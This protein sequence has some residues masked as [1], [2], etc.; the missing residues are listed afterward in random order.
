MKDVLVVEGALADPASA[1]VR[2]DDRGLLYGE[3][4]FETVR[5]YAGLPFAVDEHLGLLAEACA[6]F[7][8]LPFPTELLL[9]SI[10]VA[11]G[12]RAGAES[13]LR[14]V[15]TGGCAP[16]GALARPARLS[17]YV[18]ATDLPPE[19]AELRRRGAKLV[20]RPPVFGPGGEDLGLA[21]KSLSYLPQIA[22][23]RHA[24]RSGADEVLIVSDTGDVREGATA[25]IV[26]V[27][28]GAL[29]TPSGFL[30]AGV[31]ARQLLA[32][33]PALGLTPLRRRTVLSDLRDADGVFLVSTLREIVPV[34][35]IDG[36]SLAAR[37]PYQT[38]LDALRARAGL[39]A[40][41]KKE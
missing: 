3:G 35:A 9:A 2:F 12:A 4:A 21:F 1:S 26:F 11:L 34:A 31:T 27:A 19:P 37:Y 7:S 14:I 20:T 40:I 24:Q 33:A 28:R 17:V 39:P 41:V 22:L 30:R 13:A 32:A 23:L 25:N 16:P 5:T 15:V 10:D 36:H 38:L 18:H 6:G 8:D 29:I